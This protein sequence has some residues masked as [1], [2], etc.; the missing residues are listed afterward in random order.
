[1]VDTADM[2]ELPQLGVEPRERADAARNREKVLCA[3]ARLFAERGVDSVSMDD[4]AA[5]AGVGKGTL[6]RRFGDRAGLARA[7]LSE[8][9]RAFQDALLRGPAPLGPGAPAT[10]RLVAF[11]AGRLDILELS[12]ELLI[13]AESG[14]PCARYRSDVYAAHRAHVYLLIGQADPS[15]DAEY[16][17]DLLLAALSADFFVHQRHIRGLSLAQAKAHFADLVERLLVGRV[18][19]LHPKPRPRIAAMQRPQS[20]E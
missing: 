15:A 14:A 12:H 1:M 20:P 16:V 4:V 18:P 6:F 8:S 2:Q 13:A 5:A 7:V 9:E 10:E 11:G 19:T 17:A 3:A